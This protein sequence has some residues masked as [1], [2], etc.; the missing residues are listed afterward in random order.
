MQKFGVHSEVGKLETAL[1][2]RPGLAQPRLTPGN[3]VEVLDL[4]ELLAEKLARFAGMPVFNGLTDE[5]HP[6]RRF[7]DV[8]TMREHSDKP[9]SEIKYA[10]LGDTCNNMSHSLMIE[11][12]LHYLPAFHDTEATV[13][14]QLAEQFGISSGLEVTNDVFESKCNVAFEQAENRLHTIKAILVATLGD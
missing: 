11:G 9:I 13:G 10:F 4:H 1:V 5:Y 14:K 7:A 6:T 3:A 12:C 2:G 8:M